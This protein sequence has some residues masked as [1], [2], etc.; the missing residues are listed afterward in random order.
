MNVAKRSTGSS[1]ICV[2]WPGR[3]RSGSSA[4]RAKAR[5]GGLGPGSLQQRVTF[6]QGVAAQEGVA[7]ALVP[8]VPE[9]DSAA[10]AHEAHGAVDTEARAQSAVDE[11]MDT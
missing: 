1:P 3:S 2:P 9:P 10:G 5:V 4:R 8:V 6:H 7:R 11:G